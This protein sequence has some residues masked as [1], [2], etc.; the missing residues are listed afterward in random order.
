MTADQTQAPN[1]PLETP[2]D[3]AEDHTDPL[4]ALSNPLEYPKDPL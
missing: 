1:Y 4:K 2:T 3:L